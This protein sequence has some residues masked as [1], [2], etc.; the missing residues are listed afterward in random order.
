MI[1]CIFVYKL[2]PHVSLFSIIY[3]LGG[4]VVQDS[5]IRV[6]LQVLSHT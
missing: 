3:S 6:F 5:S 1:V 2:T 4:I